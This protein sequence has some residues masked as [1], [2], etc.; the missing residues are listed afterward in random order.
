MT[1]DIE[2]FNTK[3]EIIKED[4]NI[5]SRCVFQFELSIIKIEI[6]YY[7]T[8]LNY[9]VICKK[10]LVL[11][12]LHEKFDFNILDDGEL[13]SRTRNS[14]S[15]KHGQKKY[16]ITRENFFTFIVIIRLKI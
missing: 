10:V 12:D 1:D 2:I 6:D 13:Q 9:D 4:I 3:M 7:N 11:P 5:N 16:I 15:Q 8:A 14:Y